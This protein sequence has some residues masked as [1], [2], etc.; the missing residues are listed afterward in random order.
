MESYQ[1]EIDNALGI[2][3]IL[4]NFSYQFSF[5]DLN[6][7]WE[8]FGY[9]KKIMDQIEARK[10]FLTKESGKFQEQMK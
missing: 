8:I 7:K 4:E 3:K 2:Y 1:I 5:E 9:P 6:K 10:Q